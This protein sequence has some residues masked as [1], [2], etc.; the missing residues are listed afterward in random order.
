MTRSIVLVGG[1]T[2]GHLSPFIAT[3][4]AIGGLDPSA[5]IVCV[6]TAVGLEVDVIPA[7]GLELRLID[8][9]PLPRR[10]TPQL[11]MVPW[12][13]WRASR[14]A[15]AILRD[16]RA[17]VVVGFGG[18]VSLPV[19]LAA[20][21]AHIPVVVQEQNVLP[22][23]ANKVAARFAVAVLT[24]FPGTPLPHA[25][26]SG[27]PVRR[28]IA[29]LAVRG[30]AAD[31]AAARQQNGLPEDGPVLLVSGGSQGAQ[32]LNQALLGARDELLGGGVSVLHIWGPLN[33]PDDAGVVEG[34]G[35]ARYVPVSY[36][37]DMAPA[38]AAADLMLARAGASTVTETGSVGLPCI[39]VPYAVGNGEQRRNAAPLVDHGAGLMVADQD[40]TAGLLVQVAGPLLHD[41]A[42]LDAMGR[43]AQEVI[44]PGSADRVAQAVLQAADGYRGR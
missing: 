38:Y 21:W 18:Y 20:R 41:R 32:R 4:E 37:D 27:M 8:P 33:F 7:A 39:F 34:A 30:R 24:S 40:L 26:Y 6:G 17:D 28:V 10:L 44:R 19:Y 31:R 14:Q 22:G 23:L 15:A 16:V 9:V 29:D 43:A 3:A 11:L 42:R 13:L 1:G 35:G 2:T 36:V 12:R 25:E 5:S